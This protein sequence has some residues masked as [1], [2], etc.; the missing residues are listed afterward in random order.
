MLSTAIDNIKPDEDLPERKLLGQLCFVV[1]SYLDKSQV[2]FIVSAFYFS[3]E[4]HAGQF[5]KSGEAYICHPLSVA[6]ILA[7]MR[8]DSNCIVAGLLH[9][10]I[11][12][13]DIDKERLVDLFNVEVTELVDGVTKLS[14]LDS[15][16]HAEAQAENVR[17]MVLAMA[18]DL[19]VIIIKLADRLHNMQTIGSMPLEKQ[20]RIAKETQEIYIPL[21]NRLSMN[22]IRHQLE[23]L[24]LETLYPRR[25]QVLKNEVKKSRGN[26]RE[27]VG[28]LESAIKKTFVSNGSYL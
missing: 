23:G 18:K 19:R 1:G 11:E 15:K 24:C 3:A 16:S 13:T 8:M 21:A 10:V 7:E 27:I 9:D 14:Q 6:I 17:K 12:D 4:C 25:Y 28:A 22:S 20:R 2:D 26:R 5:R